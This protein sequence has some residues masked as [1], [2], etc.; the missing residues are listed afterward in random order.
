MNRAPE[1]GLIAS[2][3]SGFLFF[4]S[5]HE[6]L[7]ITPGRHFFG[8]LALTTLGLLGLGDLL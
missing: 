7:E 5:S 3:D 4:L 8:N 1:M 6:D 2:G